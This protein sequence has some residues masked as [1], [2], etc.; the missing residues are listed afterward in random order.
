MRTF[1]EFWGPIVGPE[2]E[3]LDV[4]PIEEIAVNFLIQSF[5]SELIASAL[6]EQFG[7]GLPRVFPTTSHDTLFSIECD[8]RTTLDP[9]F[10]LDGRSEAALR[11]VKTGVVIAALLRDT[12]NFNGM[13]PEDNPYKV[14]AGTNIMPTGTRTEHEDFIQRGVAQAHRVREMV[15]DV[16]AYVNGRGAFLIQ[17]AF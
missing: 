14:L 10:R 6:T 9:D 4:T 8:A 15:D 7:P 1:A 2:V 5:P 13:L 17:D 11:V 3:I 12:D 16:V